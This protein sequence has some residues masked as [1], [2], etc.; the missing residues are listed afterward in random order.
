MWRYLDWKKSLL[1]LLWTNSWIR[2]ETIALPNQGATQIHLVH[3]IT[4]CQI[5]LAFSNLCLMFLRE[6]IVVGFVVWTLWLKPDVYCDELCMLCVWYNHDTNA[7]NINIML[8]LNCIMKMQYFW[9][10]SQI[11]GDM[12]KPTVLIKTIPP[13]KCRTSCGGQDITSR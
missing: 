12:V 6:N 1:V 5:R 9:Q 4:A 13:K 7:I 8:D 11:I 2:M 3:Q 10:P